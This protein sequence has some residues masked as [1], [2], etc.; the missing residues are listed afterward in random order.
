MSDRDRERERWEIKRELRE[1]IHRFRKGEIK[2][3]PATLWQCIWKVEEMDDFLIKIQIVK[4]E[5]P[6]NGK[7]KQIN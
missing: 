7:F 5:T 3:I 1:S 2:L 6:R 4:I